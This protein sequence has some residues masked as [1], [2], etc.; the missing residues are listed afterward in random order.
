M[1]L[2]KPWLTPV[3]VK[4]PESSPAEVSLCRSRSKRLAWCGAF[5]VIV[6]VVVGGLSLCGALYTVITGE[7]VMDE[8]DIIGT[9]FFCSV[10]LLFY[11]QSILHLSIGRA[12]EAALHEQI[13]DLDGRIKEPNCEIDH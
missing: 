3:I 6:G 13:M 8:R 9:G 11:A 2:P 7:R 5:L 1:K 10:V 12:R 4:P